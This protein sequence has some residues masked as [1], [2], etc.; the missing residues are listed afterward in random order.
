Y[1]QI[2]A[3]SLFC[4]AASSLFD[5]SPTFLIYLTAMLLMTAIALVLLTFYGHDKCLTLSRSD[6]R[7]V[8]TA[9]LLMPLASLPL[10]VFFFSI[11]PRTQIPLWNFLP[12]PAAIITGMSDKVEPGQSSVVGASRVLAF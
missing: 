1:L 9:G 5:L 2:H 10:L 11:L 3:L 12:A 8:L 7:T 6:M 4:L